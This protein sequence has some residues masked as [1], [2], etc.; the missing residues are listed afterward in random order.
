MCRGAIFEKSRLGFDMN[1]SSLL[2]TVL[3]A[4]TVSLG[5][6]APASA[7]QVVEYKDWVYGEKADEALDYAEKYDM[8]LVIVKTFRK[9][10]C[11]LCIGAGRTMVGAKAHKDMVRIVYYVGEGGGELNSE[12]VK[13]LFRKVSKQVKDPSSYAP[14]TYY[15]TFDGQAL[16]FVPYEHP[17]QT[18]EQGKTVLQIR[19]W[20]NSVP[21]GVGKADKLAERGRYALA[22]KEIDQIIKRDAQVSHLIQIQVGKADKDTKMPDRPVTSFFPE[23]REQKHAE[24]VEI[25]KVELEAA[26]K[27]IVEEK[28]REAQRALKTL[29]RGPEDFETTDQ[30]KQLLEEVEAKL[31]G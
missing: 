20:V 10:S 9:T 26:R 5:T 28:L 25:A 27:L 19:E 30:A 11:P 21:V 12:R 4:L 29:S 3:L 22:L 1:V 2:L 7:D 31:R 15:T 14:D 23:L 18:R 24:Y 17:N 8:P 16:G 13:A 6:S